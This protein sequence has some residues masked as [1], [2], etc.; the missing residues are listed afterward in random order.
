MRTPTKYALILGCALLPA[1]VQPA[2]SQPAAA[3]EQE[4]ARGWR[5]ATDARPAEPAPNP[6]NLSLPTQLILPAGSWIKI[7]VD[8]PLS[9]QR[10]Q[11]GDPFMATLAE[12]LIVDGFV[13]ARRGQTV[14]GQIGSVEKAGRIKGTARMGIELTEL[15]L[16]DGRQV[17]VRSQLIQYSGDTSKGRDA[18]AVATTT[19]VGAAIG[20]AADGGFGAGMGAIAGAAASGIAVLVTRGRAAEVYPEDI[21]TFRTLAPVEVP[22]ERGERAFQPVGQQD[23]E[24]TTLQR[25]EARRGPSLYPGPLFNPYGWGGPWGYSPYGYGPSLFFYSGPRYYR[26]YGGGFGRFGGGHGRR[27]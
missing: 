17:P 27:R 4:P 1:L 11:P 13:V 22:T 16:V 3:P 18:A 14:A 6:E 5:K 12:P 7:R 24:P 23:Y 21:L 25:R 26:S 2:Y 8:Q 15:G 20:A 10:N 9:S 19:G